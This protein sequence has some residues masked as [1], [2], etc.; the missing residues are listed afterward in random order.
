M[1]DRGDGRG[2]KN[3]KRI[4]WREKRKC[5]GENDDDVVEGCA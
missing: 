4:G 5:K 2:R 1:V 3:E